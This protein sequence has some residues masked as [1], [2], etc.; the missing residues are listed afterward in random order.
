ME[1]V[2]LQTKKVAQILSTPLPNW[3]EKTTYADNSKNVKDCTADYG[4]NTQ[5]TLGHKSAH[6]IGE[7]LR[8]TSSCNEKLWNC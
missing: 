2:N 4:A 5:I 8:G 1:N 6:Y 7:K 3:P